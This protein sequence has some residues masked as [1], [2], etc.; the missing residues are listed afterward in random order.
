MRLLFTVLLVAIGL[1]GQPLVPEQPIPL[2]AI[3]GRIDHMAA[4]PATHRVFVAALGNNTVEVVDT[5]TGKVTRSL[6]GLKHPQGILFWAKG[7]RFY[8]ANADDGRVTVYDGSSYAVLKTF[9]LNGGDAD[10][11][12][13]DRIEEV[14]VGYGEGALGWISAPLGSKVGDTMLD[15]H[16]E[17]F[18]LERDGARLFVNVPEAV[19]GPHVT[20][21]DR[22]TRSVTAK[23]PLPGGVSR[24]YPMALDEAGHRLFVGCRKPAEM[25]VFDTESGKVVATAPVPG[26]TDDLFW[27]AAAKRVYVSGGDGAVAVIDNDYKTIA[28]IA[29]AKGARTS[30]FVPDLKRLFVAVPHRGKQQ[31]EL[32]V[33]RVAP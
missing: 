12:R 2:G 21:V 28:T 31:P 8:V 27:D 4:D 3:E 20:V 6:S 17:S 33:Y 24:N 25:L 1:R 10:N 11:I 29:T 7:N 13:L 9:D 22:R 18:Q 19:S 5:G 26:D 15:A 23:W 32:L 14:I 16:P 30:L